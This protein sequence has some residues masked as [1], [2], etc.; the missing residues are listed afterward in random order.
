MIDSSLEGAGRFCLEID[1]APDPTEGLCLAD[2]LG[3]SNEMLQDGGEW[4][5]EMKIR[6]YQSLE[7]YLPQCIG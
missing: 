3:A 1:T 2:R 7:K 5:E 6:D 4:H